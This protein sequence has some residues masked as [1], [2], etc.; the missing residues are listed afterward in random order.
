MIQLDGRETFMVAVLVLF[1]GKYLTLKPQQRSG[2]LKSKN[3]RKPQHHD[4]MM[5][6]Q[7]R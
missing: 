6:E 7:L 1:L 5:S 2:A 4:S 3:K